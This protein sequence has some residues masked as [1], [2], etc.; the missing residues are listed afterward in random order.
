MRRI[1]T[2]V[3][4]VLVVIGVAY[5]GTGYYFD[6][7]VRN[8]LDQFIQRLPPG[9]K[10]AYKTATYSPLS[11]KA[12]VGGVEIHIALTSGL[13]DG[14]IDQL[15]LVRPNLKLAD[16]WNDAV[17][18]PATWQLDQP[19]PIA[20]QILLRGVHFQSAFQT[21]D[22]DT[23]RLDG[24]RIYP[25]ALLHPGLPEL[26]AMLGGFQAGAKPSDDMIFNMLRLEA[27]FV[28][29]VGC[30][31]WENMGFRATGKTLPNSGLPEQ[32]FA[33]E[34][35]QLTAKGLDRGLWQSV[36]GEDVS[37]NSTVGGTAKFGRLAFSG[38]D[39]RQAATRL[40]DAT[41][42][43]PALFDGVA[44]KRVD[45]TDL[46]VESA[47][48]IP[49]SLEALTLAD[50]AMDQG[51][52]VSGALQLKGLHLSQNQMTDPAQIAFFTQL[53][54]DHVT[55]GLSLAFNRD[56]ATGRATV[57]DS[58]L[59]L[60]ELG[61]VDLAADLVDM[62]IGANPLGAKLAKATLHYRDASLA[63]RLLRLMARGG[64]P[65]QARGELLLI[66]RQQGEAFGPDLTA[67]MVAFLQK[68]TSLTVEM[69]PPE[70]LPLAALAVLQSWPRDQ[71]G[72]LLGLTLR[73]NQ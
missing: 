1:G 52:P 7:V 64:D 16:G 38:M 2:W 33:Y 14:A 31:S 69:A 23:E 20:D 39:V 3:A 40:L 22:V 46:T 44:I 13:F 57:H 67:A 29:G 34:I 6:S 12:E 32:S 68:P 37:F 66:A 58:Y 10:V 43:A 71:I 62:P 18:N 51:E 42:L 27:A 49:V 45:Y 41:A 4:A 17:A 5:W 56:V 24:A 8:G 48:G 11:G 70:P 26:G 61:S 28:L 35:A 25:A 60:D 54:I 73:A 36:T 21:I 47:G 63:D 59:K 53:G 72:K 55:V 30:D 15:E 9:Y 19:L 50:F 65:E